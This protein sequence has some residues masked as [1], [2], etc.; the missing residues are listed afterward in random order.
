MSNPTA[1]DVKAYCDAFGLTY[2]TSAEEADID[3]DEWDE[4]QVAG[5]MPNDVIFVLWLAPTGTCRIVRAWADGVRY[6]EDKYRTVSREE[7]AS[8]VTLGAQLHPE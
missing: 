1:S 6:Q 5:L 3:P 7:M 8:A 2:A 4:T